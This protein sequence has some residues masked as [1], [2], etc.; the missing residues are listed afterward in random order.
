MDRVE[1]GHKP[2]SRYTQEGEEEVA[3][4]KI[5]Y[6]SR[7]HSQLAQVLPELSKLKLSNNSISVTNHHPLL[8][9]SGAGA[10]KRGLDDEDEDE[11]STTPTTR[12]VSLG[13]R[14]QLCIN[15]SLRSRTRDLDE[16]CRELLGGT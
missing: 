15:D 8:S 11:T 4:T 1:K 16:A 13:S 14:K 6:A 12:T 5:Y 7:T 10:R 3:C 2:G 9:G